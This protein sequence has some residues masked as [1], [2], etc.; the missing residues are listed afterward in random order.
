MRP[1]PGWRNVWLMSKAKQSKIGTDGTTDFHGCDGFIRIESV[2]IRRIR[3]NPWFHLFQ[4][5]SASLYFQ[6]LCEKDSPS[7]AAILGGLGGEEFLHR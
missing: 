4:S 6:H 2:L 3:E 1:G 7:I 5:C